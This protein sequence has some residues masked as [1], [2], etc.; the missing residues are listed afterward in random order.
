MHALRKKILLLIE[1]LVRV[2]YLMNNEY[3]IQRC[4]SLT[5]DVRAGIT[6]ITNLFPFHRRSRTML[7]VIVRLLQNTIF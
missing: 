2:T 3:A 1:K 5:K 7:K 4:Y 6:L